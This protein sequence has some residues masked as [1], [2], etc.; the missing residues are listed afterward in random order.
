MS[1]VVSRSDLYAATAGELRPTSVGGLATPLGVYLTNGHVRGGAGDLGLLCTGGAL[2]ALNLLAAWLLSLASGAVPALNFELG[3]PAYLLLFFLLLR[4]SPLAQIHASEHQVVHA[5]E[6][7]EPLRVDRVRAQP[8]EHPRCGTNLAA[9]GL[10]AQVLL[11]RLASAA[12]LAGLATIF[13][14]FT[15]KRL[16][17]ALQHH[18]TTRLATD[19]QLVEA[20]AAG[21]M[22]LERFSARPAYRAPRWRQLWNTGLMQIVTGALVVYWAF[23]ALSIL[24]RS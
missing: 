8:R 24:T 9:I 13:L 3:V 14:F 23:E 1:G 11:P 16:G 6:K 12:E 5:I 2:M 17:W 20:I 21:T 15:W 7:G 4:L 19:R 10:A 18:F 22:I